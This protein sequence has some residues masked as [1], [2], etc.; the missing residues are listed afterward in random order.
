MAP[1]PRAE[2]VGR[3][4]QRGP[5]HRLVAAIPRRPAR[6][7][8]A[9][10]PAKPGT[11]AC[12]RA[13]DAPEPPLRQGQPVR[14]GPEGCLLG[15]R[16]TPP[17]PRRPTPEAQVRRCCARRR[18]RTV[19][20]RVRRPYW[21]PAGLG[22][23]VFPLRVCGYEPQFRGSARLPMRGVTFAPAAVLPQLDSLGIVALALIRLIVPAPAF[24]TSEGYGDPDVPAGHGV[25]SLIVV[26]SIR[27]GYGHA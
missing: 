10:P 27:P 3:A 6:S 17:P 11:R 5:P 16:R 26:G 21:G 8:P 22:G 25:S 24:L 4:G 23:T 1:L 19:P 15:S 12:S 13:P 9:R 18:Y 7:R 2:P 14:S 20:D